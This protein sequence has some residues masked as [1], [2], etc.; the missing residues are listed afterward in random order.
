M[1]TWAAIAR[2][3]SKI[4]P[5]FQS[6][7]LFTP[8]STSSRFELKTSLTKEKLVLK[9]FVFSSTSIEALKAKYVESSGLEY[10][11]YPSR[12]EASSA[13]IWS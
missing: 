6:S 11:I 8:T 13:F 10:P 7:T 9:R 5:Q 12:I 2:G 3:D 4:Y 1:K